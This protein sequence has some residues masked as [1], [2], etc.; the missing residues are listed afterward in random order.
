VDVSY[1]Q[2]D[3]EWGSAAFAAGLGLPFDKDDAGTVDRIHARTKTDHSQ[4]LIWPSVENMNAMP[5]WI[6]PLTK[7]E[8]STNDLLVDLIPW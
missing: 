5:D 3:V 6:M 8:C 4:W 2:Q 1:G 7:Q